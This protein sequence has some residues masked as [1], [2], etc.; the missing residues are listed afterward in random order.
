GAGYGLPWPAQ[1][2]C[3]PAGPGSSGDVGVG[4]APVAEPGRVLPLEAERLGVV[5]LEQR[6]E[7]GQREE[8]VAA[9]LEKRDEGMRGQG[10]PLGVGELQPGAALAP[11][12][13]EA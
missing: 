7:Q 8:V 13:V 11:G 3:L 4:H 1:R 2:S 10:L 6:D 12:A 9:Q 5:A